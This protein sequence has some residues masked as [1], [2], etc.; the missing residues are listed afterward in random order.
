MRRD[1]RGVRNPNP[2]GGGVRRKFLPPLPRRVCEILQPGGNWKLPSLG[3]RGRPGGTGT[4]GDLAVERIQHFWIQH[5][6]CRTG[7]TGSG[8]RP[9]V[10]MDEFVGWGEM[11]NGRSTCT[12]TVL[13]C[14][15]WRFGSLHSDLLNKSDRKWNSSTCS[16]GRDVQRWAT[17]AVEGGW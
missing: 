5:F 11:S 14:G 4:L 9:R 2:F 13:F 17:C 6:R 12:R 15:P 3:G 7:S 16:H 1:L 8:T 10:A